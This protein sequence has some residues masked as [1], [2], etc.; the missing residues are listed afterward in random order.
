MWIKRVSLHCSLWHRYL[1]T[2]SQKS[3]IFRLCSKFAVNSSSKIL[4]YIATP[5]NI[6]CRFDSEPMALFSVTPCTYSVTPC[7]R[8]EYKVRHRRTCSTDVVW[9]CGLNAVHQRQNA[10]ALGDFLVFLTR[11]ASVSKLRHKMAT[12][13]WTSSLLKMVGYSA[14]TGEPSFSKL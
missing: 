9:L 8:L 2:D 3:L 11:I 6:W 12:S 10:M 5:W 7:T 14:D 4:K 13:K 1:S